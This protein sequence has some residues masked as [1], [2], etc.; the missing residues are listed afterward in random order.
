MRYRA[1]LAAVLWACLIASPG[2]SRASHVH[3][4]DH[5][6]ARDKH[7]MENEEMGAGFGSRGEPGKADRVIRITAFDFGY[8]PDSVTVKRGETVKFVVTNESRL[9]HELVLGPKSVQMAH[10]KEMRNMSPAEMAKDMKSDTNGITVPPGQ[11]RTITWTFSSERKRIQFA[12]HVPGH[13][14]AGMH[15][16]IHIDGDAS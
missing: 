8:Q 10:D 2:I 5:A 15:G 12:C 16:V 9:R 3:A 7:Q 1:R 6:D 11:T 4:V 13:Y 14:Q